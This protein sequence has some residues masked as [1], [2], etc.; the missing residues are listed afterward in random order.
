MEEL[1]RQLAAAIEDYDRD[2]RPLRDS[3]D[4]GSVAYDRYDEAYNSWLEDLHATVA[5]MVRTHTGSPK[6]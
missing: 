4:D 5:D 2:I 6:L 3:A 1:I